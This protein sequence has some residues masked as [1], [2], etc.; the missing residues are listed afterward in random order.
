[1]TTNDISNV[2][3]EWPYEPG[4]LNVRIVIADDG[5]ELVQLRME[6][7]IVQME[8]KGRPDGIQQEGFASLL[9]CYE[10]KGVPNGLSP[11]ACRQLREE[12]VQRS[13]RAAALYSIN[14]WEDVIHD[15]GIA[16]I[17]FNEEVQQLIY[18]VQ[19]AA[20]FPGAPSFSALQAFPDFTES[21]LLNSIDRWLMPYLR[22]TLTWQQFTQC[23]FLQQLLNELDYSQQQQ[24]NKQ[25]PK[26]L[27]LPSGRSA[28]LT[29]SSSNSVVLSVRMTELYGLQSHP[30]VTQQD[31]PITVELLSPAG[32]PI[33]TTQD[34]P[35]FWQGSYKEVQ[36]DMKGRYP[37]HYWPD[38][39]ANAQATARTKKRMNSKP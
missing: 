29:Y 3:G 21:G 17:P 6:M 14:R 16:A 15:K 18:R 35:R 13:H 5:R 33:Q 8:L 4:K 27:A 10:T 20:S 32:R 19:F 11:E 39:P 12:G 34:L 38:D 7:G 37:R 31:V 36:K 22:D 1:M 26:R 23:N 30:A 25:L 24:L 2:L 9:E 28:Q